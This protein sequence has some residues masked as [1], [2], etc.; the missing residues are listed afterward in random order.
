MSLALCFVD[1]LPFMKHRTRRAKMHSINSF[2]NCNNSKNAQTFMVIIM[3]LC[4]RQ[5]ALAVYVCMSTML[6]V[7]YR[8][9]LRFWCS[10]F[11]LLL[12]SHHVYFGVALSYRC[13][14]WQVIH[15][16]SAYA[17]VHT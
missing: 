12:L 10:A 9:E 3:L 13:F 16:N 17:N 6:V 4:Q 11:F 2:V 7:I 14:D 1:S 15:V 8:I 5:T